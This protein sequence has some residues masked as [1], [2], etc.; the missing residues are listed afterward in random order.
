MQLIQN[1]TLKK[2]LTKNFCRW[3]WRCFK[4][5]RRCSIADFPTHRYGES[6]TPWL[7]ESGSQFLIMNISTNSKPNRNSSKTSVRTYADLNYANYP[8]RFFLFSGSSGTTC[9]S[10]KNSIADSPTHRYG[11][12]IF[13]Y[14]YLHEF[15][16][17]MEIALK[18]VWGRDLSRSE[19]CEN[20]GKFG[21]LPCLFNY[22][23][24]R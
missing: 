7:T 24:L 23:F 16:A 15:E 21:S 18:L 8:C 22:I 2:M 19:L 13:Y 5:S 11:E 1:W 17:K 6:T 12:S 4:G 20:I 9:T 14:E 10:F 3:W